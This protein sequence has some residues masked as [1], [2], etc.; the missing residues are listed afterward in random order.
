MQKRLKKNHFFS[1]QIPVRSRGWAM[2]G[3][4]FSGPSGSTIVGNS[5][6]YMPDD[7]RSSRPLSGTSITAE[8]IGIYIFIILVCLSKELKMMLIL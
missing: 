5:S 6:F 4:K 8:C 2:R 3:K 1:K 7:R